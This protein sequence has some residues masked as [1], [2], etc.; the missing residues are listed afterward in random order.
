MSYILEFHDFM[1]IRIK[2]ANIGIKVMMVCLMYDEKVLLHAYKF[3]INMN[4]KD[5]L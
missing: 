1:S 2:L 5:S 4:V 3:M